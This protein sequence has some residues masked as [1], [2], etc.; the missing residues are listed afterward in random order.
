MTATTIPTIPVQLDAAAF[1]RLT[2]GL[3][4]LWPEQTGQLYDELIE[5]TP[6]A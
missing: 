1:Q 4:L 5:S 2:E 6:S 3:S